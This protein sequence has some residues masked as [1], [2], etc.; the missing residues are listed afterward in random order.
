MRMGE[1]RGRELTD[2]ASTTSCDSAST[3]RLRILRVH[4]GP[5]RCQ[6]YKSLQAERACSARERKGQPSGRCSKVVI[7]ELVKSV[8]R[9]EG[10]ISISSAGH[11]A[12]CR[13]QIWSRGKIQRSSSATG[14]LKGEY[15][16]LQNRSEG[17][18]DALV[19]ETPAQEFSQ[20]SETPAQEFS[21]LDATLLRLGGR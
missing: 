10:C 4:I 8:A 11:A 14:M 5:G 19:S 12:L 17:V 6:E 21:Q 20:L 15:E 9:H 18:S 3:L 16:E 1:Y 13:N 7:R 2:S